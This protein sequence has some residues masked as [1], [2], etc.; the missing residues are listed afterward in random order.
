MS[1]LQ[2]IDRRN[3]IARPS[4]FA[5]LRLV[6]AS[7]V[8]LL[9]I[10]HAA[11]AQKITWRL[12]TFSPEGNQDY[13]EYVEVFVK[14]VDLMTGG[15][16]KIQP[17]GAGVLAPAF[18]SAAAVQKG[19]ADVALYFPAFMVNQDPANAFLAGLPS[20]MPAEAT[21]AWL[22]Y[23]GGEK[24][25]IDFRRET[26]GLHPIVA[27]IGPTEIFAHA[28]KPIRTAAD[29]KGLKF[30]TAGAWAS[31]MRDYFGAS[32][33]VLP[34][35]E[36]FTALERHVIDGT[37]YVTPSINLATGLHNVARYVMTPG[38]HQPTYVYEVMLKKETWD[39]LRPDL[40]EKLVAAGKLTM[41]QAQLKLSV[42][43]M[44]AMEKMRAG[45]NEFVTLDP[46]LISEIKKA[47]REWASKTA[48]EQK[49]KGNP[50][51]ERLSTS[52][53]TFQDKWAQSSDIRIV[54][55][56]N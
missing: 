12:T 32:P 35:S 26:M 41:M 40:K 21:M 46:S 38:V 47:T 3:A 36:I 15:E 20:G 49:A 30:R 6:A 44:E 10:S 22:F 1:P 43:D 13:R 19:I 8:M 51:M 48:A 27:G 37:E 2:K 14:N 29:L 24:L 34:A 33:T 31:I 50:W 17:F 9:A 53:F 25:W 28:H 18:E 45:K 7:L 54:D 16:I 42:A 39:A 55:T 4:L 52:Y 5:Y 56:K 11:M 23:G